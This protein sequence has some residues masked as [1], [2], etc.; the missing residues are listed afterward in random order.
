MDEPAFADTP[1]TRCA[2]Y[3]RT[4]G[5]PAGIHPEV[6]RIVVKAGVVGGITMPARLGQRVRDELLFRGLAIGPIVAHIRSR[7]WTFLCRPDL[8]VDTDLAVELFR[9]DVSIVP[10]GGEI[11]LPSPADSAT[12]YRTWIVPPRDTFRP[13]AAVIVRAARTCVR[14]AVR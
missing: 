6:G 2:Y 4:C 3:R 12:A 14:G 1:A 9:L 11:A 7:R 8:T 5:L 13:S 10:L